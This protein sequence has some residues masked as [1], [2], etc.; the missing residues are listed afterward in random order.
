VKTRITELLG[1]EFPII[2]AGMSAVA[3][4]RLAAAVSNAGGLGLI[5]LTTLTPY[6][7]RA[8]L[9][10]MRQLTKNPFGINMTQLLPA[11]KEN[12]AIAIE[13]QVP[14]INT[15]FG[16][17]DWYRDE[18]HYYGGKV[19]ATTSNLKHALAAQ[20]QGADAVIIT[21]YEAAAHAGEVGAIALIPAVRDA[22][23]IPIIAAGGIA[24]GRGLVAALALGADAVSMG[25]R[26]M[27]THESGAH[28][29]SKQVVIDHGVMDTLYSPNFDGVPVRAVSTP[30]ARKLARRKP[31]LPKMLWRA[32]Q[33]SRISNT[34]VK[35]LLNDFPGNIRLLH[36]LA[37]LGHGMFY[38][39]KGIEQGDMNNGIQP[40]GQSQ[41]IIGELMAADKVIETIMEEARIVKEKMT[42]S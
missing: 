12:I 20:E 21:S 30:F 5:N 23:S 35:P 9:A 17:C 25:S 8:A 42:H 39:L 31:V 22:L 6:E 34:P 4:P 26:F 24:D 38:M 41:G 16:K 28:A 40:I 10:E 15:S 1:I 18:V 33:M 36:F 11:A 14:V 7:A 3:T 13:A 29:Y 19:F 2:C 32:S 27:V 37:W